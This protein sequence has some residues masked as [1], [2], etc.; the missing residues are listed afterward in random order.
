MWG[1]KTLMM[2]YPLWGAWWKCC[3]WRRGCCWRKSQRF[4]RRAKRAFWSTWMTSLR[5][6]QMRTILFSTCRA[7]WKASRSLRWRNEPEVPLTRTLSV[8]L[9]GRDGL[10]DAPEPGDPSHLPHKTFRRLLGRVRGPKP[11]NR[12]PSTLYT[13]SIWSWSLS[14][15]TNL[16]EPGRHL[17]IVHSSHS[18]R[19]LHDSASYW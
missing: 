18:P 1:K 3:F 17:F 14:P 4:I 10:Y 15:S 6:I 2:F 12:L 19:T 16:F 8:L 9:P 5:T 7:W 11:S 13:C